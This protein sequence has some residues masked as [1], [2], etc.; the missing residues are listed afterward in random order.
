MLHPDVE[1]IL[2]TEEQIK[3]RIAELASR[4]DEDY[5]GRSPL[6]IGV[7]KG[8]FMFIAD[9]MRAIKIDCAVEFLALSSYGSKSETSGQVRI[10]KDIGENIEGRDI[11]V[12][13]DILDSGVT[14]SYILKLL[15]ARKPRSISLCALLD[16]PSRRKIPVEVQYSGF[17]I[18]DEFV[19]GY[20]LDY[21]ERYR[22]I[23][24][25]GV[26]KPSIYSD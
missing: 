20:G 8:S 22:N 7:L 23:P 17:S 1:S 25:I 2:L 16:K 3:T 5:V 18:P 11:I 19:V 10:I 9:L 6:F 15:N 26:L 13:E 21:S 4:I 24:Y 14:L 12:V